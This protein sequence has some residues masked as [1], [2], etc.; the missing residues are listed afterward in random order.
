MVFTSVIN[1]IRARG[2][3]EFW[4]KR[5]IFRLTAV[6]TYINFNIFCI[7]NDLNC[8]IISAEKEIVIALLLDTLI[9]R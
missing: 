2:P 5:K 7:V 4:R 3:D 6:C 1:F 9:G 8:S